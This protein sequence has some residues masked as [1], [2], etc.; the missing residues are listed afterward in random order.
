MKL[1]PVNGL[2]LQTPLEAA[3]ALPIILKFFIDKL[4]K[5]IKAVGFDLPIAPSL[6]IFFVAELPLHTSL[7]WNEFTTSSCVAFVNSVIFAGTVFEY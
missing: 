4:L 6:L 3:S 7:F 2:N 5:L 1:H